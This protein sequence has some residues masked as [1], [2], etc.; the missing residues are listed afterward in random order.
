M[1]SQHYGEFAALLV[2][3]FW[4]IT[5]LSFEAASKKV[6]SLPVNIIR[7]VIGLVFLTTLN[8]ILR[9]LFLPTDATLH[10]WIWLSV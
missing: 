10:N 5:A 3:L 6:G 7:L 8:Y 2:A 9:G 1:I 4:S